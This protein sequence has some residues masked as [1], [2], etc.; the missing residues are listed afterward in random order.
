M[1]MLDLF[2]PTFRQDPYP[3]YARLRAETP[4]HR[5]GAGPWIL[6]RYAET[7]FVL[8]DPGFGTRAPEGREGQLPAEHPL[9]RLAQAML[10]RDPPDHTRL[11]ALVSQAFTRRAVESLVPRIGS[12]T[13][14]LADAIELQAEV[15]LVQAIAYP[16]PIAVICE[17]LAIPVEDRE[18]FHDWSR[19]LSG[20]V[21][22]VSDEKI[23]ARG[24]QAA[25]FFLG[26]F[27]ELVPRRWA[28]PGDDLLSALVAA[29]DE[30]GRLSH[31][32][33]LSTCVQLVFGGHETTQNLIS[34]GMFA[35]LRAPSQ[36][37][38]LREDPSLIRG[39]IEEMLRF[40]GPAQLAA[41]WAGADVE[42]AGELV[43]EGEL[44]LCLIGS[45]NRDGAAFEHPDTFDVSRSDIKHLTFGAGIHFC[46]G[47]PLARLEAR[48]VV[49]HL[50]RR[51]PGM[52][53]KTQTPEYRPI[54]AL[55]GLAELPV[56]VS[57]L[58][59][60]SA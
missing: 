35:L 31:D 37:S 48:I 7:S 9:V 13:R 24:A 33:L 18:Q 8:T 52:M 10:F 36:L 34:N 43:R 47:A 53:L 1:V 41:R 55:R 14:E 38:A 59:R 51:F 46:L 57:F 29:E 42:I 26:Y 50:V 6:S 28:E 11:R 60:P 58:R 23:I 49:D 21:D 56:Q 39:A 32:E 17:L 30:D 25:A 15:D 44:V 19:Q 20:V 45:A 27:D 2:D 4:I 22:L 12:M 3:T 54:L 16:L 40:D 5:T